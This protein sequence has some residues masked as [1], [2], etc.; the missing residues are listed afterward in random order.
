VEGGL[1]SLEHRTGCLQSAYC[2]LKPIIGIYLNLLAIDTSGKVISASL[3]EKGK[4]ILA[5]NSKDDQPE[6]SESSSSS[7]G[8]GSDDV[9]PAGYTKKR[10]KRG[11]KT[12]R[13]FPPGASVLLAPMLKQLTQQSGI[14]FDRIDLIALTTGPGLFTGIRV[15]VVSGKSLAYSTEADLIGLNTLEVIAA[16]T[17][18]HHDWFDKPI[19]VVL[20]AQRQQLFTGQYIST[21][22]WKIEVVAP[23]QTLTREA[24]LDVN[25]CEFVSGSGLKP[26]VDQLEARPNLTVSAPSTW[27]CSATSVGKLAWQQYQDGRRD[28]FWKLEPVYFRP[29]SAEEVRNAKAA[30]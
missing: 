26:M 28:D 27:E 24:W 29:S 8:A 11:S 2:S 20:N 5:L 30:K 22:P 25:Q 9:L 10:S 7:G 6:H 21:S 4:L 16:Q 23:N 3:L 17:A 1:S 19:G 13:V 15:G 12:S 18:I 14:G